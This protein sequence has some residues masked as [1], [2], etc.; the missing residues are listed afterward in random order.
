MIEV[1]KTKHLRAMDIYLALYICSL[2]IIF[3]SS[4]YLSQSTIP[5]QIMLIS[6]TYMKF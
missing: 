4:I 1:N 6:I 3:L 5:A 2:W